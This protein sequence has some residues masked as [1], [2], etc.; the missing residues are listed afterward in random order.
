[1]ATIQPKLKI[2]PIKKSK[3]IIIVII[4]IMAHKNVIPRT[5]GIR[6]IFTD[7][8]LLFGISIQF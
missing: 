6:P 7:L 8:F 2:L 1:M 4:Q 5:F 3:L